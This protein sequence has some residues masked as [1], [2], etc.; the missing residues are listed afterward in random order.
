M[1]LTLF[2]YLH[3]ILSGLS[4]LRFRLSLTRSLHHYTLAQIFQQ[5]PQCPFPKQ[6][7]DI[8]QA[9]LRGLLKEEEYDW[10]SNTNVES[11]KQKDPQSQ[12]ISSEP[13]LVFPRRRG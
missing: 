11:H 12:V 5:S 10:E 4:S 3:L 7:I 6:Q 8:F 1:L 2:S 13:C 9:N